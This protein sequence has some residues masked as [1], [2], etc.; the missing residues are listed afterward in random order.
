M[1]TLNSI[2][3]RLI[4][5]RLMKDVKVRPNEFSLAQ[6]RVNP[7]K[8]VPLGGGYYFQKLGTSDDDRLIVYKGKVV[9]SY[10]N[11]FEDFDEKIV[12]PHSQLLPEHRGKGVMKRMYQ[13]ILNE[14]YCFIS[15]KRHSTSANMLWA[16]LARSNPWFAVDRSNLSHLVFLGQDISPRTAQR[17]DVRLVLLGKGWTVEKFMKETS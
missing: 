8:L 15:G 7:K 12:N 9:G 5:T 11:S 4:A 6:Y 1:S 14:G 2:T 13:Q 17:E 16:A 10:S 3:H